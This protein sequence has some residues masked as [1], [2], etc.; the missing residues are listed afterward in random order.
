[1]VTSAE[2]LKALRT[3]VPQVFLQITYYDVRTRI[4]SCFQEFVN[5]RRS[6]LAGSTFVVVILGL[7]SFGTDA[8]LAFSFLENFTG[9]LTIL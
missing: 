8:F 7:L 5:N 2:A 3:H 4:F 9:I 1:M 6:S